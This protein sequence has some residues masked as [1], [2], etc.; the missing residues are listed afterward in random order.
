MDDVSR[1]SFIQLKTKK[2]SLAKTHDSTFN[3][4]RFIYK[5]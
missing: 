4:N 1:N 3:E 5:N 2:K